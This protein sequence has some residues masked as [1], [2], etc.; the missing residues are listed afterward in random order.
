VIDEGAQFRRFPARAD[1]A[2]PSTA[3][4][5]TTAEG[6]IKR[7]SAQQKVSALADLMAMQT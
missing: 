3:N 7:D 4:H 2:R 5:M 1:L 6:K